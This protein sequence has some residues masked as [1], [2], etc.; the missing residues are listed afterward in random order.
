MENGFQDLIRSF[1]VPGDVFWFFNAPASFQGYINKILAKKL[2]VFVIVYLDDILIYTKD[3]GQG[4]IK[5]V[6]W[7][8]DQLWKHGLFANLKKCRFH[9]NEVRF[10][11][12]VIL[13][14]GVQMED[15]KMKVVKNWPEPKSVWYIQ[16]FIGFANFYWHFIQGFSKITAL[17]TS[18][19]KT[20]SDSTQTHQMLKL[21]GV[22]DKVENGGIGD[23][24]KKLSKSKK[25][26][27]SVKNREIG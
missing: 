8:L 17:V 5:A 14:Q 15:K 19:L 23:Q 6:W 13:A 12:Y 11:G 18:M 16:V 25:S 21:V 1:R 27:K 20:S 26:A 24:N 2:D 4:Q 22:D 10:L 3:P 9:Q 7:V